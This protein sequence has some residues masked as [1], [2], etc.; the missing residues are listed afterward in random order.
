[1]AGCG[2]ALAQQ[3]Y[4]YSDRDDYAWGRQNLHVARDIGYQDGA[5][6]ARE[7][8][9]RRK[10]YDPY[11]RGKYAKGDHGYRHEYGNRYAYREQY[12]RAYE[13]GYRS[14]FRRY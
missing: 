3:G 13:A 9:F 12:A 10:L 4:G 6:V 7:D 2:I 14:A 11:P 8:F 1:M 5:R